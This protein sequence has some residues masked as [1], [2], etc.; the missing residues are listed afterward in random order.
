[1]EWWMSC[2]IESSASSKSG[3]YGARSAFV[4]DV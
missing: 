3:S 2:W 4:H 1:M